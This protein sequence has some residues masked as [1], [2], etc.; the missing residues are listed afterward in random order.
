MVTAA[1]RPHPAP[2]L[3][4][5]MMAWVPF[6]QTSSPSVPPEPSSLSLPGWSSPLSTFSRMH[7][8][9]AAVCVRQPIS[10]PERGLCRQG[11]PGTPLHCTRGGRMAPFTPGP[12]PPLTRLSEEPAEA[13]V[14]SSRPR[15]RGRG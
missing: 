6:L 15:A 9:S 3:H 12:P 13:A 10:S 8:H 14:M 7:Q 5:T 1:L 4:V 2:L 11:H